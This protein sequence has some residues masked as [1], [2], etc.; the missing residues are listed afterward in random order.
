MEFEYRNG[1]LE[2]VKD[3]TSQGLAL[4]IYAD[5][6]YSAHSTTDLEPG[7]AAQASSREAVAITRALEPDAYRKITPAEL[8]RESAAGG[9]RPR[10][11]RLCRTLDRD[12]RMRW[13]AALD[14]QRG[15]HD[16]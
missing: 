2:K 7:P 3:S 14:A 12:Q 16:A 9:P 11:R 5:G 8:F 13:C 10:R 4:R 6:R 1:K 15:D